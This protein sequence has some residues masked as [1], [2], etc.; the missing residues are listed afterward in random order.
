MFS[1]SCLF[2][3]QILTQPH[4]KT[5]LSYPNVGWNFDTWTFILGA[6]P[7]PQQ[8][9]ILR[10]IKNRTKAFCF[11]SEMFFVLDKG[12]P[13][14]GFDILFSHSEENCQSYGS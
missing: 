7:P 1:I 11:I 8:K 12:D 14:L 4:T 2:H 9:K 5:H 6:P 13:N 10:L 3:V